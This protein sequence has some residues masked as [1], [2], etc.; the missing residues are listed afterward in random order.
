MNIAGVVVEYNPL[1]N[2]HLYHL[3]KTKKQTQADLL[4]AV[5]SGPF[6]QRGEPAL[7][8]KWDRTRLALQAGV[9]LVIEL[10]YHYATQK[11]EVFAWGAVALLHEI[12]ATHLCFG[13]EAGTIVPFLNT[14][15][16]LSEHQEDYN[17]WLKTYLA[18]GNSYPK[19]T[20]LA[21]NKLGF[22][23]ESLVDLSQPNNIL[24]FHYV[25][26]TQRLQSPIKVETIQRIK[27][28][29]HDAEIADQQIASATAIRQALFQSEKDPASLEGLTPPFT[30]RMLTT[31]KTQGRLRR[32]DDYYPFLKY[33]LLT[34]TST[35]LQTI[36]EAEEGLE[37]RLKQKAQDHKDF[38]TFMSAIKTKRYTWTRLQRLCTHILTGTTKKEMLSAQNREYP[39]YIR[40]LGMSDAGQ[41]Y[42]NQQKKKLK[43]PLITHVSGADIPTLTLDIKAQECYQLVAHASD[44]REY[45]RTP[46]RYDRANDTFLN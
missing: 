38:H 35:Q 6:L 21:F 34:D 39:N 22:N 9:D 17:H 8:S 43:L 10:P 42:L 25:E 31:L 14:I 7:L 37:N 23:M 44:V 12:G 18:D 46:I 45:Q 20:A 26:A 28:G 16:I 29:Y 41:K 1:H 11:A 13:S 19:A 27:A 15:D 40:L 36:Y 33:R 4:V 30:A 2:G 5:M 3:Q 32:W 24:G